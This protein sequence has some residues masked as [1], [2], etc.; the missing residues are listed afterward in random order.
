MSFSRRAC[1]PRDL[2]QNACPLFQRLLMA[3]IIRAAD[4]PHVRHGVAL[5]FDDLGVQAAQH[6]ADVKAEAAQIVTEASR[7]AD[8]IRRQAADEGRR[9]GIE[10]V[11]QMVAGQLAPA[12]LALRKTAAEL[13]DAKQAWLAHWESSAVHLAAAMAARV[14]RGEL[15]RQPQITLELVREA[16][17][18]AA[19]SPGVCLHLNPHD[20]ESLGA[21][22]R[23]L[24]DAISAVGDV[25][26]VADAMIGS[27]G[28][29]IETRFGSIDQQFDSQ[30]KRIEEELTG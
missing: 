27:G 11:E 7:E 17:E 12:I 18:L 16:L 8:S 3:T 9:A 26:V 21:Q 14:V 24:I 15:R 30:L 29:R 22:V 20:H 6:L 2:P 13:Q 19:G 28:C 23:A 1:Q 5:N 10:E 4:Q 25:E